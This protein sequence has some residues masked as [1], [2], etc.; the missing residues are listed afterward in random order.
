M[1]TGILVSFAV[2][3]MYG[4]AMFKATGHFCCK[5]RFKQ[6]FAQLTSKGIYKRETKTRSYTGN[7]GTRR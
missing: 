6:Y 5:S 3:I 4:M 2:L 7:K 1:L